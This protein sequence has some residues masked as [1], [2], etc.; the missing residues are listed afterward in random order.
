MRVRSFLVI[1]VTTVVVACGGRLGNVSGTAEGSS[2]NA[3][4]EPSSGTLSP[5]QDGGVVTESDAAV[6]ATNAQGGSLVASGSDNFGALAYS[7]S[8]GAVYA[9]EFGTLVAPNISRI[10]PNGDKT[11]FATGPQVGTARAMAVKPGPVPEVYWIDEST[12]TLKS[13]TGGTVVTV[14]TNVVGDSIAVDNGDVWVETGSNCV[15]RV[16]STPLLCVGGDLSSVVNQGNGFKIVGGVL[17]TASDSLHI[18]SLSGQ[19]PEQ[20]TALPAKMASCNCALDIAV[21]GDVVYIESSK[22]LA[23]ESD[24]VFS[25]DSLRGADQM[26]VANGMAYVRTGSKIYEYTLDPTGQD[27]TNMRY[28]SIDV[29]SATRFVLSDTSIYWV[30]AASTQILTAPL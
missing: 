2:G 29:S 20:S 7:A 26:E 13:S 17:Y 22:G 14:M 30:N 3:S 27:P 15:A 19:D 12:S 21:A 6:L 25:F 9:S 8:E 5:L 10:A 16:G 23:F 11:Q 1:S 4:D 28:V 18:T 24:G